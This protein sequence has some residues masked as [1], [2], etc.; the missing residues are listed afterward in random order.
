MFHRDPEGADRVPE[1]VRMRLGRVPKRPGWTTTGITRPI[2]LGDLHAAV[3]NREIV[4]HDRDAVSEMLT[5]VRDDKGKPGPAEGQY[6]DRVM[7]WALAVQGRKWA[8]F[9][10]APAN[11]RRE[12]LTVRRW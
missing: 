3:R 1:I 2:M 12:A 8:T 6:S 10:S 11:Q 4:I 5:F 9:T 7:A